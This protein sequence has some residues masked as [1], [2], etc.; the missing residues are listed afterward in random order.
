MSSEAL[1]GAA[2]GL[3]SVIFYGGLFLAILGAMAWYRRRRGK[4]APLGPVVLRMGIGAIACIALQAAGYQTLGLGAL[5]VAAM[6]G[7]W[8]WE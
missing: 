6:A 7:Y 8:F 5:F 2:V 3:I 1:N 4:P